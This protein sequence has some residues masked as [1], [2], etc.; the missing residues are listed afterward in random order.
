MAD[1]VTGPRVPGGAAVNPTFALQVFCDWQEARIRRLDTRAVPIPPP[2]RDRRRR[3]PA[4]H[5]TRRRETVCKL[6]HYFR[7][8]QTEVS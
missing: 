1:L 4:P 7:T 6:R 3:P 2:V 5:G 8:H